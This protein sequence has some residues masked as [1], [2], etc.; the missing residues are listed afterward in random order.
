MLRV[1]RVHENG[2]LDQIRAFILIETSVGTTQDV[3]TSLGEVPEIRSVDAIT[4]PYDVIT[5]IDAPDLNA[6]GNVVS[7]RVHTIA[8]V[9][10]TLTC[11]TVNL[12]R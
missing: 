1:E 10:R 4:G 12:N 11:L 8:G 2:G 5:V 3:V 7:S 9:L 6:V